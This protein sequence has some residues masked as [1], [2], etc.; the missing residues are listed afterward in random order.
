MA[1]PPSEI[2]NSRSPTSKTDGF[3]GTPRV[4]RQAT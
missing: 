1:M 4:T 3:C 2:M